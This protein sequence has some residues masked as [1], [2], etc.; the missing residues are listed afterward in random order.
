MKAYKG[1]VRLSIGR[2]P[3]PSFKAGG[4]FQGGTK[5]GIREGIWYLEVSL[6]L[7][8]CEWSF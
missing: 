4:S 5:D 2:S 6:L 7:F 1:T 8:I 3:Y